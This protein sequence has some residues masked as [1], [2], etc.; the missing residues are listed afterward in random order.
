MST[1]G[2][3]ARHLAGQGAGYTYTIADLEDQVLSQTGK[4]RT[5]VDRRHRDLR[6]RYD[7]KIEHMG[8]GSYRLDAVGDMPSEA[9]GHGQEPSQEN[10]F[11]RDHAE[12]T[13]PL[14][15]L[16][17]NHGV[18]PVT[19]KRLQR[20]FKEGN[21]AEMAAKFDNARWRAD[22]PWVV[23]HE[24][25]EQC[26]CTD[27]RRPKA[28]QVT[29]G[30]VHVP[31]GQHVI[32]A[33]RRWMHDQGWSDE[34]IAGVQVPVRAW[35]P[36]EGQD[37][38]KLAAELVLRAERDRSQHS[39]RDILS[40][41]ASANELVAG[42]VDRSLAEHRRSFS[43]SNRLAASHQLARQVQRFAPDQYDAAA[44]RIL[45]IPL[46]AWPD[47]RSPKATVIRALGEVFLVNWG[48]AEDDRL[49]NIF[50]FRRT[51]IQAYVNYRLLARYI[52]EQYNSGCKYSVVLD[53]KKLI[54]PAW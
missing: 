12:E 7:W 42:A 20:R 23:V 31:R 39:D 17:V 37:W 16:Y 6:L 50:T 18:N 24:V 34:H 41:E 38:R 46:E 3:I 30:T 25:V 40:F 13:F 2:I 33:L 10:L 15:L 11:P 4:R 29:G 53:S 36:G 19:G 9:N 35:R 1:S 28:Y 52:C 22:L 54:I 44:A 47:V 27:C 51:E 26:D 49:V 5:E 45:R 14:G 32:V 48:R 8:R 21:A 43:G